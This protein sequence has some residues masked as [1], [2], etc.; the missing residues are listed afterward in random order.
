ML[1]PEEI[2][3]GKHILSRDNNGNYI[4]GIIDEEVC[5]D[6]FCTISTDKRFI[7]QF[8]KNK[9]PGSAYIAT[10]PKHFSVPEKALQGDMTGVVLKTLLM[11]SPDYSHSNLPSKEEQI[12][13]IMNQLE[14]IVANY[15]PR[16]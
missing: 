9:S 8:K 3:I 13:Q 7:D 1:K 15:R 12:T 14:T 5:G 4:S 16:N 11:G 10:S 2:K 6:H